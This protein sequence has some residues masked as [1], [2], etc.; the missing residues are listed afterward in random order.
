MHPQ[1]MSQQSKIAQ[2]REDVYIN[3]GHRKL[4]FDGIHEVFQDVFEFGGVL[5]D[6]VEGTRI[7][8]LTGIGR[9]NASVCVGW[10]H[11]RELVSLLLSEHAVEMDAEQVERRCGY[12]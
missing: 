5:F 1:G 3:R 9:L 4:R 12:K 6:L 2:M 10:I 8:W 7:G 11:C